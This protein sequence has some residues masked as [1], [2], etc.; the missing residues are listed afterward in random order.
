MNIEE[1]EKKK[2]ELERLSEKASKELNNLIKDHKHPS[3]LVKSEMR[4]TATYQEYKRRY[5]SAAK[6]LRDF[7]SKLTKSQQRELTQRR[8]QRKGW[9]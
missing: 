5:E 3:G 1:I 8:R 9:L 6:A 4:A 7:N 2:L